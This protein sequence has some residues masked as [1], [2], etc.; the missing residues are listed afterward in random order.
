[1][2]AAL[3]MASRLPWYCDRYEHHFLD[4]DGSETKDL[5][6]AISTRDDHPTSDVEPAQL[7]HIATFA[8]ASAKA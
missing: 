7:T 4:L 3:T 1:M 8:P 6:K 5:K 2:A